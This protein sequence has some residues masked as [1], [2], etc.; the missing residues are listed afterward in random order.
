MCIFTIKISSESVMLECY[1]YHWVESAGEL[2]V[3]EDVTPVIR[4]MQDTKYIVLIKFAVWKIYLKL[5]NVYPPCIA[6]IPCP[7]LAIFF[8][9][10]GLLAL[11]IL[12]RFWIF[13]I[14]SSC[15]SEN[16]FIVET[17][18]ERRQNGTVNVIKIHCL[19][20]INKYKWHTKSSYVS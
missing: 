4:F 7:A 15:S 5:G 6:F 9:F 17:R 13:P 8:S 20:R 12:N 11:H 3:P 14:K 18:I 10:F 19:I 16:T 1:Y 2:L